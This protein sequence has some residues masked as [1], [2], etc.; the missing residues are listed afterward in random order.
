MSRKREKDNL[1]SW[2][3]FGAIVFSTSL[4][5]AFNLTLGI[6]IAVFVE[7]YDESNAKT[8]EVNV[9]YLKYA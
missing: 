7:Y 9:Q 3:H 4:P 2:L 5:T 6:F 1:S 8:G